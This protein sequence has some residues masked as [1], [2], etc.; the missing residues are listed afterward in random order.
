MIMTMVA[1]MLMTMS[2]SAQ[3][4]GN[5]SMEARFLTEKMVE[6][7]GL[8][9]SLREKIY[10]L[11]F[12]YLNGIN[13]R[14][15]LNGSTWRLRNNKLK[16][17]LTSSQW[18]KY[19][20][21][22]YFY[23]PISWRGNAYVHNIYDKYSDSRPSFGGNRDNRPVTLPAPPN[24]RPVE[25]GRP[26]QPGKNNANRGNGNQRHYGDDSSNRSFGSMRR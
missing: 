4:I 3:R 9:S 20:K 8:N 7:L 13:G 10:Q 16:G 6:E 26:Q 5:A 12:S 14:D 25:I 11:N 23:R 18:K 2:V 21:S 22:S 17:V 1:V 24:Q 19:K 15:D